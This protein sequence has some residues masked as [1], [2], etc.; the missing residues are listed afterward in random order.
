MKKTYEVK[1]NYIVCKCDGEKIIIDPDQ[2]MDSRNP[3][4]Y[5]GFSIKDLE[6]KYFEN[7]IDCQGSNMIKAIRL[8]ESF[9]Y[10]REDF[11]LELTKILNDA[12]NMPCSM[13]YYIA[14]YL[15]DCLN[16]LDIAE[17][18]AEYG[19]SQEDICI[20]CPYE[21]TLNVGDAIE[22]PAP[23]CQCLNWGPDY[24]E[25]INIGTKTFYYCKNRR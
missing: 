25:K 24:M 17:L 3:S 18:G 20:G 12:L 14:N 15:I 19:D 21:H 1:D 22:K 6:A 23:T 5:L 7:I 9:G 16:D 10:R 2:I 13:E 11:G 8:V 4:L